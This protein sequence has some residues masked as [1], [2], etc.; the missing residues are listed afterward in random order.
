MKYEMTRRA[1]KYTHTDTH[2]THQRVTSP[3]PKQALLFNTAENPLPRQRH[4]KLLPDLRLLF[5]TRKVVLGAVE[6]H[7]LRDELQAVFNELTEGRQRQKDEVEVVGSH[8]LCILGLLPG[9]PVPYHG[10]S[11]GRAQPEAVSKWVCLHYSPP[12]H[13]DVY[14]API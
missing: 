14:R 4:G 1:T 9:R 12:R 6:A 7:C 13:K 2:T 8:E 10:S 11:S 3:F 5:N